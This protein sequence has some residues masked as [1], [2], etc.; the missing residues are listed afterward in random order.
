MQTTDLAIAQK[1]IREHREKINDEEFKK[2]YR[3][4]MQAL[5]LDMYTTLAIGFQVF[6]CGFLI[7]LIT[8]GR[9]GVKHACKIKNDLMS[10]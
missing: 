5:T 7:C 9:D 6:L 1:A 10:S 8:H 4:N 3:K 2:V